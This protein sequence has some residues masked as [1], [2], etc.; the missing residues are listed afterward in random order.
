MLINNLLQFTSVYNQGYRNFSSKLQGSS[1]QSYNKGKATINHCFGTPVLTA[2]IVIIT[3]LYSLLIYSSCCL[4]VQY[5]SV[6]RHRLLLCLES[7]RWFR[8]YKCTDQEKY[9]TRSKVE[10]IVYIRETLTTI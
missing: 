6:L 5:M 8:K 2:V 1:F 10:S 7:K 9:Q 4:L 3:Y